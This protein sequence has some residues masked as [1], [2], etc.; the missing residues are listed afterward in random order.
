MPALLRSTWAPMELFDLPLK[1]KPPDLEALLRRRLRLDGF[2][3]HQ[4]QVCEAV[5]AGHD[6][7]LVMPTGGGKSLCYQLPGLA[8]RELH[9]DGGGT[10]VISPLIAL[11]EDQTDK[12]AKLGLRVDRIHSGR[13]RGGSNEALRA[14]QRGELDFLMVAPERLRVPNFAERLMAKPPCLIAVDEA[15]CIS[16]WGHDFRPD[17]RL[18]GERL[19]ELRTGRRTPVVAMTATATERVQKDILQQLGLAD[20]RRF[21]H[22][23]RRDNLQIE[24]A[25]VPL[26]VRP[27]VARELLANP[28]LR[29][30]IVYTLARKSVDELVTAW[31]GDG[32]VAGYHAGME[33]SERARVQ[34][35][36]SRGELD[37]VVATVAFGMGIDKADIRAVVHL[38]LPGSIE[39][40]YQEIGRAGRDGLPSKVVAMYSYADRKQHE[41]FFERSYP[42]VEQVA[43]LHAAVPAEGIERD[44]LLKR[45]PLSLELAEAALDKLWGLRALAI[46]LDDHVKPQLAPTWRD[47]YARQRAFREAQVGETFELAR[48]PGCRMLALTAYFGDRSDLR[49]CG[50]C[51]ACASTSS[52]VRR[53]RPPDAM[54]QRQLVQLVAIVGEASRPLSVGKIQREQF[55]AIDRKHFDRWLAGLERAGVVTTAEASFT[56]DDGELRRYRTVELADATGDWLAQVQLDEDRQPDAP[57]KATT[58]RRKAAVPQAPPVDKQLLAELKAWRLGRARQEGVPPF[59]VLRDA[60]L[61]VLAATRPQTRAALLEVPGIGPRVAAKYAEDLLAELRR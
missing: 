35:R 47:D 31:R 11:M 49:P 16:M 27:G 18:L 51:D 14:W 50:H 4:R 54:E 33:A 61:E 38:G 9:P 17:Y 58:V 43:L 25:E 28:A 21:I 19:P 2:R 53:T 6:A 15:H 56:T 23:F 55:A 39:S 34:A 7:L 46:D 37:I 52:L 40:W 5:T 32:R 29:P 26:N 60:T 8:R 42:T 36:F 30:A 45:V 48:A 22:G 41:W 13:D 20:A 24:I 59:L 1:P 10:L 57:R 44:R 3:P 12:L